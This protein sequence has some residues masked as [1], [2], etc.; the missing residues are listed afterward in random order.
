MHVK[1]KSL[2]DFLLT[3]HLFKRRK[4]M[5]LE[6]RLYGHHII[7]ALLSF[8]T[9][10]LQPVVGQHFY[11]GADLS[12]VNEMEDCGAV[13]KLQNEERDAYEIFEEHGANLIRLRL[14]HTPSWYDNLNDGI[15]YSDVADVR[16]SIMR[17]KA[18]GMKVLLDFQLSDNWADPSHQVVPAAWAGVVDD[19]PVLQDSLYNY[20]SST[21]MNLAAD[22]LL[23]ELVQIGNETNKSI[24]QTQE[25]NDSGW[26]LDWAK[27]SALFNT[28]FDA[29]HD[30]EAA[31]GDSIRIAIHI[32]NPA[33]VIWMADQFWDHG[34]QGFDIIGISYYASYH[35]VSMAS[36]GN[37]IQTLRDTYPG[38][39]VMILE[40]AYPWTTAGED[41]ANNLLNSVSGYPASPV[42]QKQWMIDLTQTVID[43]GGSGVV[44]W[45]PA[46][47]STSCSTQWAQG[48]HWENA[49]FFDFSS[50]LHEEGGIAWLTH[51]YDFTSA[52][53]SVPGATLAFEVWSDGK[54]VF[55][56]MTEEVNVLSSTQLQIVAVDG[57]A[58][59]VE[60]IRFAGLND[61]LQI[62]THL[63]RGLY[64][65]NV[66]VDNEIM[67]FE[68]I[69]IAK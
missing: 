67:A 23:P 26:V 22:D 56:K 64:L 44:Y 10:L 31:T 46:W 32:A 19:V 65:V 3:L 17:A 55:L 43:H 50:N 66:V 4:S 20:I 9:L 40:T 62:Q 1:R 8:Q 60:N 48:S 61:V 59:Y 24:L 11:F 54:D 7:L 69:V 13:Y 28:A 5:K 6:T 29:I 35:P 47:I 58:V 63:E 30:V 2:R 37:I 41:A 68:K 53:K 15:R 45:E 42:N 38:K 12:Y 52:S 18:L 39:D 33:D 14:W 16:Q 57:R 27:N 51:A 49:T 36:T 34:V 21:L 25:Q